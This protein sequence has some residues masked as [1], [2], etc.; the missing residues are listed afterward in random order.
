MVTRDELEEMLQRHDWYYQYSDDYG[1]YSAGEDSWNKLIDACDE[2]LYDGVVSLDELRGMW[3]RHAPKPFH[4]VFDR[5]DFVREYEAPG[6]GS[7]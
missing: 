4:A 3:H 7:G 2:A 1:V 5:L 6:E